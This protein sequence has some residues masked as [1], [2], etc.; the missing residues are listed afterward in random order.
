MPSFG[1]R[2]IAFLRYAVLTTGLPSSLSPTAP[3][4][5]SASRSV[6]SSLLSPFV[7][8]A[9]TYTLASAFFALS[10]MQRTV[11]GLSVVGFVLG[12]ASRLVTPPAAAARQ[13][14]R[15]SSLAV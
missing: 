3:A 6:G 15:I 14:V 7:T 4:A 9:A 11:S 12:I 10:R 5:L 13:P 2:F 1:A 8:L